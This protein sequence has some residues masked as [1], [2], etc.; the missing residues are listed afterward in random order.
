MKK[1]KEFINYGIYEVSK[2]YINYL[3]QHDN[4]VEKSD[5]T[6][7]VRERKY[8]AITLDNKKQ[9]LIPFSSPKNTDYKDGKIKGSIIPIIRLTD[10]DMNGKIELPGKLKNS[11]MIPIKDKDIKE[12]K[13]YDVLKEKNIRYKVLMYKQITFIN[14]NKKLIKRHANK[15][16]SEKIQNKI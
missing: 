6:Y 9:Y 11:S 10:I 15:I 12:I 13:K 5:G 16:Y 8:L 4:K 3:R 2:D 7:Y 1:N 14:K